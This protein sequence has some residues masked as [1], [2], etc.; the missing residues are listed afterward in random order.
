MRNLTGDQ[1]DKNRKHNLEVIVDRLI[2]GKDS[3]SRPAIPWKRPWIWATRLVIVK[4]QEGEEMLFSSSFSCLHCG[5]SF[6]EISPL[7]L[8]LTACMEPAP[9][10][11]DSV[12]PWNLTQAGSIL[13]RNFPFRRGYSSVGNQNGYYR[14]FLE[15]F[16]ETFNLDLNKPFKR[17]VKKK[18]NFFLRF[19]P[20]G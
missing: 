6:E 18:R 5:F 20:A 14:Q 16:A 12:R 3:M 8:F 4:E 2:M 7:F 11:E 19:S 13:I 17:T 1:P 10:A 15:A 9:I